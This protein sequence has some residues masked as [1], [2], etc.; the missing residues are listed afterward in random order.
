MKDLLNQLRTAAEKAK[1][2]GPLLPDNIYRAGDA[3]DE[4]FGLCHPDP[5]LKLL[6]IIER[7]EETCYLAVLAWNDPSYHEKV[8]TKAREFLAMLSADTVKGDGE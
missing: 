1:A 7:A 6:D 3:Y 8:S 5:I 4:L 2:C